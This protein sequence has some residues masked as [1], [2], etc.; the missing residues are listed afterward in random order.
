ML[1]NPGATRLVLLIVA[2]LLLRVAGGA[3]GILAGLYL[4]DL[5]TRTGR[6]DASLVGFV[7]AT[8]FLAE[9]LAS[10]PMGMLAD[11]V[12]PRWLMTAGS[13][14]GAGA[15]Q[16][17][18]LTGAPSVLFLSR[19][20]EGVGV[21]A[22][23]PALLAHL[24]DATEGKTSLRAR[25]MSFYELAFL[26]GLALGGVL[27]AELWRAFHTGAFAA[28]ASVYG[29]TALLFYA[30]ASNS[31]GYG[32]RGAIEGLR[33]AVGDPSLRRLAPV[34][35]C[36]NTIVGLWLGPTLTFLLTQPSGSDQF[37][38]GVLSDAPERI[39]WVMLWYALVFG[40]G[41]T[42]WSFAIP[43]IGTARALSVGLTA[44]PFVCAGFLTVNHSA[45]WSEGARWVAMSVT[46][47]LI[48]IESGFTPAALALLS[49]AIGAHAGR[50]AAMGIYS[51][52]LSVGAILGSLL[53]A[54]L[55]QRFSVDGLIYGTFGLAVTAILL[56]QSLRR[57][58]SIE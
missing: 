43:R 53:A 8:S 49:N 15:T 34:W 51:V 1:L 54:G 9:L 10:L 48:M 2:N 18:G 26:A 30:G 13:L 39:G 58:S 21:A 44:M 3:G 37:L 27:A 25:V 38:S 16:L 31:H 5:A 46:A 11:A 24:T 20:L 56:A 12:A 14:L 35:L 50:G 4:S 6:V 36:M 42:A 29:V 19:G 22:G 17:F 47:L 57:E 28:V 7:G 40:I 33:T 32:R 52:L 45:E 41:V 55:G 23:G